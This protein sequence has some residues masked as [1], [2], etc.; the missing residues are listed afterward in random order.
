[1]HGFVEI[2]G[3]ADGGR[4]QH[5][6]RAGDDAGL[7]GEDVA[8][9]VLG[10]D[11]VEVARDVHDVHRHGVDELVFECDVGVVLG[12]FS[13]G[14]APELRDFEDV[15]LVDGGDFVAAFA[16]EFEGDAG[17]ADDF[18]FRVA[19]GVNGFVGFLVP[20][21]G[22]AE[23]EAAEELADEENV[24]VFGDFWAQGRAFG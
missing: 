9:E 16:G 12:D 4:G 22:C 13:D 20:R 2:D 10:E 8:E 17:D 14:G 3:A 21:A 1:M 24:G 18:S 6:E 7:V 11:D 19:H 5:A 15:G 23:V